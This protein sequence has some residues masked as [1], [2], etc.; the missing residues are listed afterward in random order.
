MSINLTYPKTLHGVAARSRKFDHLVFSL[1]DAPLG[2][3]VLLKSRNL[4]GAIGKRLVDLG[5][6]KGVSITPLRWGPKG[7]LLALS[8]R[9][10]VIALRRS[11]AKEIEVICGG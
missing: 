9:N 10:T 2:S 4:C 3:P 5:F 8:I 7:N 6:T 11:E 1:A